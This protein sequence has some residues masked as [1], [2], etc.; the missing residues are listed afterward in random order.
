MEINQISQQIATATGGDFV[1]DNQQSIGGGCINS[2]FRLDGNNISYFVKH[3][4]EHLLDMF[5]AEAAGLKAMAGR[6]GW[7]FFPTISIKRWP[8]GKPLAIINARATRY[9]HR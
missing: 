5:I 1:C 6:S 4:S 9:A 2:A 8:I 7:I 3:N